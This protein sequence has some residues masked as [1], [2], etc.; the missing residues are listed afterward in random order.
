MALRRRSSWPNCIFR[1]KPPP[2]SIS[3]A[4]TPPVYG[5]KITLD[6]KGEVFRGPSF[7]RGNVVF[8]GKDLYGHTF[9]IGR[10]TL[11]SSGVA[12]LIKSNL[13]AH[14]YQVTAVYLGDMMN[15]GSR[16]SVLNQVVTETTSQAVLNSSRNPS[17]LG[18][19]VTFTATITSPTVTPTGPVTFTG[20]KAGVGDSSDR[21]VG[22]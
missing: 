14:M 5:Q 17:T 19:I 18:Q 22:T 3:T 4:S 12:T 11:D 13:N 16:S 9:A 21:A 10:A 6:C 2:L 1:L 8:I 7:Q 15:Q 20:G